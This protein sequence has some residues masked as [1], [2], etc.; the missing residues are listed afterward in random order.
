MTADHLGSPRVI[1][2]QNGQVTTRKDYRAFG[3]ETY[4]TTNRDWSF[5]I[6]YYGITFVGQGFFNQDADGRAKS[7]V[8]ES[9]VHKGFGRSDL[10]FGKTRTKGSHAINAIIDKFYRRRDPVSIP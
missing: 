7:I 6:N 5:A 2:N 4:R 10:D 3:D 8:H 1:T 9:V